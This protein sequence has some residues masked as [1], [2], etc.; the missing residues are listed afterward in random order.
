MYVVG[1]GR[2]VRSGCEW[3]RGLGVGLTN[4]VGT[5]EVWDV[6][7]CLGCGVGVYFCGWL[8]PGSGRVVVCLC[9]L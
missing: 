8:R 9:V 4:P 7:L 2:V 6:C 3:V 1:S 5:E